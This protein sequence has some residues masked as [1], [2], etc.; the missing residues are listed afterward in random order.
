MLRRGILLLSVLP[1]VGCTYLPWDHVAHD[2]RIEACY[3]AGTP[4][5]VNACLAREDAPDPTYAAEYKPGNGVFCSPDLSGS[6]C[7]KALEAAGEPARP[8]TN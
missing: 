8:D 3:Q 5:D 7:R 6:D 1:A 2:S 4:N